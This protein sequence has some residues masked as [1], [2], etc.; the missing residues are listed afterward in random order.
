MK[1]HIYI[2]AAFGFLFFSNAAKADIEFIQKTVTVLERIQDESSVVMQKFNAAKDKLINTYEGLSED[3]AGFKDKF[4]KP[5][6]GNKNKKQNKKK[7]NSDIAN[8]NNLEKTQE[9]IDQNLIARVGEGD[10]TAKNQE[11]ELKMKVVLAESVAQLYAKALTTRTLLTQ[12][13]EDESEREN[14]Q[15]IIEATT[16]RADSITRRYISIWDLENSY[17]EYFIID[18]S[19]EY[20]GG[21]D[22]VTETKQGESK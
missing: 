16:A 15:Q 3:R 19:K 22:N 18:I 17:I 2:L 1:K 14:T 4:L 21:E 7:V 8:V 12:E 20:S 5:F 9:D 11:H 10:E 13:I 6:M